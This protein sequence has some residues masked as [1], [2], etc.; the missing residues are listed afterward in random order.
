MSQIRFLNVN[1]PLKRGHLS[2][3]DTLSGPQGVHIRG[4]P[5]YNVTV[6]YHFLWSELGISVEEVW[7]VESSK[8]TQNAVSLWLVSLIG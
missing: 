6:L 3:Q 8:L 7:V 1:L 2:I 4:D 5:L